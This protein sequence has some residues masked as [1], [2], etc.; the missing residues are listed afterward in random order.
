VSPNERAGEGRTGFWR[1]RVLD[2]VV[3]LLAQGLAP[4]ALALSLAVGLVLGLFPIIGATTALCV[5][6]RLP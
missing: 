3:F 4:D 5:L 6:L 1:R 2:P